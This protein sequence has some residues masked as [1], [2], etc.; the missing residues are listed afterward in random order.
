MKVISEAERE[1]LTQLMLSE[2]AKIWDRETLLQKIAEVLSHMSHSTRLWNLYMDTLQSHGTNF[3]YEDT[4]AALL[5]T[6]KRMQKISGSLA[7]EHPIFDLG[8]HVLLRVTS[9]IR[10]AGYTELSV[11]IWQAILHLQSPHTAAATTEE[12]MSELEQWWDDEGPRFGEHGYQAVSYTHL[13][14]PTKRIV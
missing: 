11:A 13:T 3:R 10:H 8:V 14:L 5:D 1:R 6:M 9:F 7:K 2:G 12:S 4:K